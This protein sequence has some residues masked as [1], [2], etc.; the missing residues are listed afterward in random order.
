MDTNNNLKFIG[1]FVVSLGDRLTG[2]DPHSRW[3]GSLHVSGC[4]SQLDFDAATSIAAN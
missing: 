2:L 1:G 3:A 4:T